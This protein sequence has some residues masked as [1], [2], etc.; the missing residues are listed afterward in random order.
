MMKTK[1]FFLSGALTIFTYFFVGCIIAL[2]SDNCLPSKLQDKKHCDYSIEFFQRISRNFTSR[3]LAGPPVMILGSN[4]H[5]KRFGPNDLSGPSPIGNRGQWQI[6][7][8]QVERG[9]PFY[10]LYFAWTSQNGIHY[11]I[12][13]RWDDIDGYFTIFSVARRN[14]NT[15]IAKDVR[16]DDCAK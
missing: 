3:C 9:L 6:S 11:R 4:T 2:F 8:I 1:K 16:E 14:F 12:G 13:T 10:F 7:M 15:E 5:D